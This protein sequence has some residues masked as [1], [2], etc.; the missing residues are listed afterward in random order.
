MLDKYKEKQPLFYNY[1]KKIILNN[2]IS[3]AYMIET[4]NVSYSYDLAISFA[5][6]LLCNNN[7]TNND[8][9]KDCNICKNIDDN[10]YPDLQIV[11]TEKKEIKKEQILDLEEKFST[12]PLYGKYL[13]YII[14][15]AETLN[16]SSANT[17]LKF[18]EEPNENIIAI[19]LTNNI[20]NILDTIVSRCQI[21]TLSSDNK[22][23]NNIFLKYLKDQEDQNNFIKSIT[24]KIINFYN[25][26]EIKKTKII[27]EI[28]KL[29]INDQFGLY[30]TIG[31]NLYI[32]I[33]KYKIKHE[34]SNFYDYIN[35]ISFI[36]ENNSIDDIIKKIECLNKFLKDI[37]YNVNKELFINNF[38]ITFITGG[39]I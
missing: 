38:I 35:I 23:N 14:P 3:H 9:C 25:D 24:E 37:N 7:Y 16:S 11:K 13:I 39:N 19:L 17:I 5:K 34:N 28:D 1:V 15:N 10:N 8:K 30:L 36:S 26:L 18:L 33:L 31:L 12:K 2:K 4:N 21:L 6:C 20:Y 22:I 32:D 27:V 29:L